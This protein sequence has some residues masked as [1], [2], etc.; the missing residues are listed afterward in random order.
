MAIQIIGVGKALPER[1]LTNADLERMVETSNQWII[2][3][4]GIS[5]RRIAA[6]EESSA[7]LGADAARMALRTAGLS[8]DDIDL[9]VCATCTPDGMFPTSASL[10]QEAIGA[11]HAAAF[12]VNAACVGFL[13]GLATGARFIEAGAYRRVLVVG[14]EVLSRIIDW[15]DRTTC[16]LFGDGAGAV[17]IEAAER[18]GLTPFILKSDGSAAKYLYARG[19][20]SPSS[21]VT[22]AEGFCIVMDG[23]EV[24]RIAVRAMEDVSSQVLSEA[25][26]G[27]E[28]VAYVIPHQANLRIIAAV[29]KHLGLPPERLMV[30]LDKYGNT[31]SASI[32]VALCEAWEA[33]RLRPGDNLVLVAFGGGLVW[34]ASVVEWTR[35]GS[36]RL[37]A[38]PVAGAARV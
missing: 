35:L 33:G 3:R 36:E 16:V 32:P 37:D 6:P 30:N 17:V 4:T 29:A 31:S 26:L 9:I 28:D 14:A 10:I 8:A 27:V 20:A 21:S 13:A 15:T 34:G 19:P 1:V 23:R 18:P 25:G 2:D 24:F 5:E 38:E 12:D 22:E 7:S 11:R